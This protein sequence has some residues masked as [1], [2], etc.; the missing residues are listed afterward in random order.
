MDVPIFS[1]DPPQALPHAPQ[2]S[3]LLG[4]AVLHNI[5]TASNRS[6]ADFLIT[7]HLFDQEYERQVEDY[8]AVLRR[9]Q[10]ELIDDL[11]ED[12]DDD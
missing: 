8:G 9:T 3:V 4:L 1:W 7:S 2:V 5:P 6:T 12:D 10:E 11:T